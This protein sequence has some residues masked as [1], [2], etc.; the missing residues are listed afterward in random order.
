MD[1][2]RARRL[3]GVAPGAGP[4]ELRRAFRAQAH[5]THPDHGGTPDAFA[6]TVAAFE[7]LRDA[8]PR[9]LI[10]SLLP[11]TAPRIDVYDSPRAAPRRNFSD[12]LRAA[13]ARVG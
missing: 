5:C 9:R 2:R 3:L 6:Q 1:G 13:T 11:R 12:V 8:T 7:T 10:I 4:D